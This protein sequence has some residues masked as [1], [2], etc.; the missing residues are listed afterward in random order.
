MSLLRF[1]ENIKDKMSQRSTYFVK[2]CGWMANK[3]TLLRTPGD[4]RLW[5]DMIVYIQKGHSRG[6]RRITIAIERPL[7]N[8]W[9]YNHHIALLYTITTVEM[10]ICQPSTDTNCK[11]IVLSPNHL[12]IVVRKKNLWKLAILAVYS[13][14]NTNWY[15]K[16]KLV[17]D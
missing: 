2:L 8:L 6:W 5:K 1:I 16:W 7:T 9:N 3:Q 4:G 13:C 15:G 11:Y 12:I 17:D 14:R 10:S